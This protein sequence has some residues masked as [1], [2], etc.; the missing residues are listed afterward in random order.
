MQTGR[1]TNGQTDM[2]KPVVAFFNF[3]NAH[4]KSAF[5]GLNCGLYSVIHPLYFP[6]IHIQVKYIGC[7]N[8]QVVVQISV[9]HTDVKCLNVI[10]I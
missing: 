5:K 9:K 8:C 2:T 6:F 1:W 7:G 4:K 10:I 3:A